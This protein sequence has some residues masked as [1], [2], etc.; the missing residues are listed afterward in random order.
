MSKV[1]CFYVFVHNSFPL[2]Y[3]ATLR[4]YSTGSPRY[5][6]PE[7]LVDPPEKYNLKADVYTF[8]LVLWEIF[9]M[10]A[11]YSQVKGRAELVEYVG[12]CSAILDWHGASSF[13][14]N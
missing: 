6:A 12:E 11:P 4:L 9:S 2:T 7:V 10:E 1:E 13:S 5:M 8:A 3:I 14:V